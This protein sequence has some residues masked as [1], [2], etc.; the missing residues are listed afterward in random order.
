MIRPLPP[1]ILLLALTLTACTAG[2]G[3]S[4]QPS[5]PEAPPTDPDPRLSLPPARWRRSATPHRTRTRL[6]RS[7]RHRSTPPSPDS[8][9]WWPR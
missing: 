9:P 7:R 6:D 1:M 5:A 8:T 4:D 3:A 2:A